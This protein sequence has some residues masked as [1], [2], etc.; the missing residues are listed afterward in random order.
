MVLNRIGRKNKIA[1]KI[2]ANFPDHKNY[3]ETFFGAGGLFFNKPKAKNN[4]LNDLDGE[5]YNFWNMFREHKDDLVKLYEVIPYHEMIFEQWKKQEEIDPIFRALRFVYLSNF[6]LMG[7]MCTMKYR[8]NCNPKGNFLKM[9]E[10][11]FRMIGDVN[12]MC[13]DFRKV[14]RK[15]GFESKSKANDLASTFIYNDPPYLDTDNNYNTPS[16]T[17]PDFVALVNSNIDWGV[18]FAISERNNPFVIDTAEMHDLYITP[19]QNRKN[20]ISGSCAE[21]LITNY[22]TNQLK[23]F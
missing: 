12:F 6:S 14:F 1:R 5:V 11:T 9:A 3:I 7:K 10:S 23:L 8:T 22:P 20:A 19:I 13:T 4:F 18:K 15:I 2:V 21:I 17:K 16:W